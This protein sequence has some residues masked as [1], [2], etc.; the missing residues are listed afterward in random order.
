MRDTVINT[1]LF[2]DYQVLIAENNSQIGIFTLTNKTKKMDENINYKTRSDYISRLCLNPIRSK[3]V[4]KDKYSG[5]VSSFRYLD[6]ECLLRI[7]S[8]NLKK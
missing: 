4:L 1:L 3:I 5:Q 7:N 6:G 2:A 8:L